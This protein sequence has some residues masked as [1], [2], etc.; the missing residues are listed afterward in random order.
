MLVHRLVDHRNN[1][2]GT[3][4]LVQS[5]QARVD[6]GGAQV[7]LGANQ[8]SWMENGGRPEKPIEARRDLV[9]SQFYLID[10][11][12]NGAILDEETAG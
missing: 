2:T 1:R 4:V 12:T 5:G 11:L 7:T 9:G 3:W 6:G 10:D 8:Q